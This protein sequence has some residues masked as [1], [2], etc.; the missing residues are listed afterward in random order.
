MAENSFKTPSDLLK[1]GAA[2]INIIHNS[3]DNTN[4]KYQNFIFG[5]PPFLAEFS[6][7]KKYIAIDETLYYILYR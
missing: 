2:I 4:N 7:I 5:V 3:T 1:T 6:F